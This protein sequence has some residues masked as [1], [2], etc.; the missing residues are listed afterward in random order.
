MRK[1]TLYSNILISEDLDLVKSKKVVRHAAYHKLEKILETNLI[2]AMIGLNT[3]IVLI[4]DDVRL[5]SLPYTADK[6]VDGLIFYCF[7]TFLIELILCCI[8][9][10]GYRFSFFFWLDIISLGSMVSD[11]YFVVYLVVQKNVGPVIPTHF[12]HVAHAGRA[13]KIGTKAGRMLKLMR[14]IKIVRVAKFYNQ[15]TYYI[16]NKIRDLWG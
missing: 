6:Y 9:K 15:T 3:L 1:H 11:I 12:T 2:S 16:Q 10:Q 8:A 5:I 4:G 14:I 7:I 13:T